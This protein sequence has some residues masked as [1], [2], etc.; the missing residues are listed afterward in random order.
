MPNP[1][2]ATLA[3]Y[4]SCT[5][6][7]VIECCRNTGALAGATCHMSSKRM[8]ESPRTF[9]A[10]HMKF[11]VEAMDERITEAMV[12]Q[13]VAQSRAKDSSM[14]GMITAS[15]CEYTFEVQVKQVD[16]KQS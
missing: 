2:E 4:G 10:V 9:Q 8:V 5:L 12:A 1:V 14:S 15:G 7:D 16:Q 3:A 13:T 11:V 6:I